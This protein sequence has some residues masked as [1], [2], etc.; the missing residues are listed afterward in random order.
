MT[1]PRSCFIGACLLGLA[2]CSST[3][4]IETSQD[5]ANVFLSTYPAVPWRDVAEKL[6]PRLSLS[7]EVSNAF[8]AEG[9]QAHLVTLQVALQPKARNLPY[10]VY[11]N[12]SMYP[13][14][15]REAVASPRLA[16]PERGM[17]PPIMVYPLSISESTEAPG[18]DALATVGRVSDNSV[19]IRLGAQ[20]YGTAK[21]GM[22]PRT[23]NISLVVITRSAPA[24]A[25]Q[26]TRVANLLVISETEIV[27]VA[28]GKPLPNSAN[29]RRPEQELAEAVIRLVGAHG[30]ALRPQCT[31]EASKSRNDWALDLLRAVERQDYRNVQQ[32]LTYRAKG[33]PRNSAL[34]IALDADARNRLERLVGELI[35]VQAGARY[36]KMLVPLPELSAAKDLP[37]AKEPPASVDAPS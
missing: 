13:S 4:Q 5:A 24:V 17:P 23:H 2:G 16:K 9:Y 1:S 30:F 34:P 18:G 27:P 3:Y 36:A 33:L 6:E 26:P 32:C 10:D 20:D 19:R 25:D 21:Y 12:V 14:S 28:G 15:W 31:P 8:R 37:A 22:F 29:G 7:P 35:K 11:L